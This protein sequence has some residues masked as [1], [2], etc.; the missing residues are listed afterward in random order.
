MFVAFNDISEGN[1]SGMVVDSPAST[2]EDVVV[3]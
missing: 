1:V 3:V 2:R